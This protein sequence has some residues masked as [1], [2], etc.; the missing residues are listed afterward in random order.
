MDYMTLVAQMHIHPT[1]TELL[2]K[3]LGDL[4]PLE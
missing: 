4:R 2:P 1:M 3:M